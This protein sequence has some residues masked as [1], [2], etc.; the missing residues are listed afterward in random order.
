MEA[1][2]SAAG[3][4][5]RSAMDPLVSTEWLAEE[6]GAPD[7]RVLDCTVL[8]EPVPGGFEA[9]DALA[10]WAAEHIPT[11]AYADLTG[12]LSDPDSPL[13]FTLPS[14]ERFAEGMGRLGVGE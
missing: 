3:P 13:R 2:R 12:D 7:L 9:K 11:S 14:A 6:L 5:Q 10:R 4:T 1:D 8:L